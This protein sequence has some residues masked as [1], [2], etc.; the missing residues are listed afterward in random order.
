MNNFNSKKFVL[1]L[2]A[3]AMIGCIFYFMDIHS[4]LT[5]DICMQFIYVIA[6][7]FGGYCGFNIMERKIKRR[8]K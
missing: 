5:A 8:I 7:V 3:F 2:V 4:W 1:A 6:G